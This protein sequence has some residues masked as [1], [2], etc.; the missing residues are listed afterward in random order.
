MLAAVPS[1]AR[2]FP[3]FVAAVVGGFL[4]LVCARWVFVG[5][6]VSLVPWAAAGLLLG[7]FSDG[8]GRA[9]AAG[10]TYGFVLAYVFMLA[11]YD[12]SAALHTRLMPFV[13]FG[14]VGAVCGA[15]LSVAGFALRG[16]VGRRA[17][18]P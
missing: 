18:E 9:A 10:A 2:P 8:R 16:L 17:D 1:V 5:S 12:G 14:V 4:G 6:G 15:A 11:G 13:V 7:A 3:L